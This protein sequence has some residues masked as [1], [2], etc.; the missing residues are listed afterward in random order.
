MCGA[1]GKKG[2]QG[3]GRSSR[4]LWKGLGRGK[5]EVR[6]WFQKDRLLPLSSAKAG[7]Q[8]GM[9]RLSEVELERGVRL[10][11][12]EGEGIGSVGFGVGLVGVGGK[13]REESGGPPGD[14]I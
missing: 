7:W 4:E 12:E 10:D 6:T 11:W 3:G 2:R 9:R 14:H 5:G 8:A 1:N 13:E